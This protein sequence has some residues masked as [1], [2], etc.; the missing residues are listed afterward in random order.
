MSGRRIF[1][2][3]NR[4][5]QTRAGLRLDPDNRRVRAAA[6]AVGSAYIGQGEEYV[7]PENM[8]PS[9]GYE[10]LP[11]G[12]LDYPD[13]VAP[14]SGASEAALASSGLGGGWKFAF[15]L[16]LVIGTVLVGIVAWNVWFAHN[17]DDNIN[18]RVDMVVT[19]VTLLD[20][21]IQNV[22][23]TACAKFDALDARLTPLEQ[24]VTVTEAMLI[25][26]QTRLDLLE[27]R[28]TTA[29]SDI[30]QLQSD[31]STAQSD[32]VAL[33]N[34]D[35]QLMDTDAA[36]QAQIDMLLESG[37]ALMN[38]TMDLNMT[39]L[40]LINDVNMAQVDISQLQTDV[41]GKVDSV[42]GGTG[43]SITGTANDPVVN[44]A[45]AISALTDV[46]TTGVSP[47]DSLFWSGTMWL[48]SAATVPP[49][50]IITFE[51]PF[52]TLTNGGASGD[53][54]TVAA[55]FVTVGPTLGG[56]AVLGGGGVPTIATTGT[57]EV[58][59]SVR[60]D[61][62]AAGPFGLEASVC[63][64]ATPPGS[65]TSATAATDVMSFVTQYAKD[66]PNILHGHEIV[67]YTAADTLKVEVTAGYTGA[68]LAG[69]YVRIVLKRIG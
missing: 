31:M 27:P 8:R 59:T 12:E 60:L 44:L 47:G 35:M 56:D 55:G 69:S 50:N 38:G 62:P 25:T 19:N 53:L 63:L 65:C 28:V 33:G 18:T 58:T 24:R 16:T 11:D 4:N 3:G 68:V 30:A 17:S 6:T 49:P 64:T 15:A 36:Q 1:V 61:G 54:V 52:G 32:I 22:N 66:P 7:S 29:E 41:A 23:T 46:D 5:R 37:M 10:T 20:A 13:D 26:H 34:K 14:G 57:Y 9:E 42:S 2:K 43:I 39:L 40:E 48:P 67:A 21:D 45:A 51:A